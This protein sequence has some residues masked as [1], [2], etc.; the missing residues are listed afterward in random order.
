MGF[1]WPCAQQ[2]VQA[3]P[4]WHLARWQTNITAAVAGGGGERGG[5]CEAHWD[6]SSRSLW[7]QKETDGAAR[8]TPLIT[9]LCFFC[10]GECLHVH[11]HRHTRG[12][13]SMCGGKK[14]GRVL[15]IHLNIQFYKNSLTVGV[16]SLILFPSLWSA[17]TS[18]T[19][20]QLLIMLHTDDI[21]TSVT[22]TYYY[23]MWSNEPLWFNLTS[24]TYRVDME[25]K[26]LF[27]RAELFYLTNLE[28]NQHFFFYLLFSLG[29][30]IISLGKKKMQA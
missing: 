25:N 7:P 6:T 23:N 11:T 9:L 21:A 29:P 30:I 12:V 27:I 8:Q 3:P 26:T 17:A 4:P 2:C 5:R 28:I 13:L 1:P 10:G 22:D 24:V 15:C 16:S 14:T 20:F 19:S 18:N